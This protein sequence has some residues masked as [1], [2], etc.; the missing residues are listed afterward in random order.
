MAKGVEDIQQ[1]LTFDNKD[2]LICEFVNT[3]KM[4]AERANDELCII[5]GDV[6]VGDE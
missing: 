4:Y 1:D 5:L 2:V 6:W 3:A